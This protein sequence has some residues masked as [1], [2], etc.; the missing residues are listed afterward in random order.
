MLI[1]IKEKKM[2]GKHYDLLVQAICVLKQLR[3]P[4]QVDDIIEMKQ[5][6]I[7]NPKYTYK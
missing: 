7:V 6:V 4:I 1:K 3:I 5:G 2:Y